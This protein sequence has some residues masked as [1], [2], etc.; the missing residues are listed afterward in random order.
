MLVTNARGAESALTAMALCKP[1]LDCMQT[2]TCSSY[3]LIMCRIM[4]I[5]VMMEELD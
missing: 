2:S 1:L 5:I 4:V 3:T